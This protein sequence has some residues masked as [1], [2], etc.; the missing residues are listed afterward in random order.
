MSEELRTADILEGL[1]ALSPE[2][3]EQFIAILWEKRGWDT[4][5]T[6]Q[7]NDKGV[8]II[9]TKSGVYKEKALIQA[10]KYQPSNRVG[11]PDIQQYDT[12]RRQEP[13]TDIVIVVTTSEFTQ[14]AL[15]LANQ[16]NVKTINGRSLSNLVQSSFDSSEISSLAGVDSSDSNKKPV[17]EVVQSS[18]DHPLDNQPF[19]GN[20]SEIERRLSKVYEMHKSKG[21]D[22]Y[23]GTPSSALIIKFDDNVDGL[24]IYQTYSGLHSIEFSDGEKEEKSFQIV[25]SKGWK[26]DNREKGRLLNI[27]PNGEVSP[28]ID[29]DFE[30][31]ITRLIVED[32][33]NSDISNIKELEEYAFEENSFIDK[34]FGSD[35]TVETYPIDDSL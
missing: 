9:A 30:V 19:S 8:D 1:L 17:R 22:R 29:T 16:L 15:K 27:V 12:L 23:G 2:E 5:I 18:S 28:D 31:R 32:V 3:F 10:K 34:I 7:N 14:E 20:L 13:D 35:N 25:K 6:S 4:R 11:R 24:E 26:I 33:L 21:D